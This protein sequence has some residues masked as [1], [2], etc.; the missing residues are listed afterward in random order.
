MSMIQEAHFG[1]GKSSLFLLLY[2]SDALN[3][4][5]RSFFREFICM[6]LSSVALISRHSTEIIHF[7]NDTLTYTTTAF[8][9]SF[10]LSL[11]LMNPSSPPAGVMGKEGRQ[12]VRCADVGLAQFRFLQKL[13]FVHGHWNYVRM[14]TF[15]NFSFYKNLAFNTPMVFYSAWSAYSTQV[16]GG[17][18]R[19]L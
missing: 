17:R 1:I 18:N 10:S 5:L 6:F 15:V 19:F 14:S 9:L 7:H 4:P 8:S 16:C 12:A 3:L 2:T 13:L 11:I